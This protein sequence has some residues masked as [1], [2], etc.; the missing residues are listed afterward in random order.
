M[1]RERSQTQKCG[2]ILHKSRRKWLGI[3]VKD[4]KGKRKLGS[5]GCVITLISVVVLQMFICVRTYPVVHFKHVQ[6]IVCQ[7]YHNKAAK[8]IKN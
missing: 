7:E 6:F 4:Y 1:L 5:D 8:E 2:C 3:E